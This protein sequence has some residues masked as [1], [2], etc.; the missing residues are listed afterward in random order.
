MNNSLWLVLGKFG[1]TFRFELEPNRTEREVQV[2]PPCEAVPRHSPV[3]TSWYT[4]FSKIPAHISR[5]LNPNLGLPRFSQ[6]EN[7]PAKSQVLES[8]D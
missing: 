4:I 1:S 6:N 8:L 7:F 2:D 5:F 3:N